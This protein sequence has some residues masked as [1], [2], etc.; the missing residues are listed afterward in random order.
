VSETLAGQRVLIVEDRYLIASEMADHVARLGGEVLGP[1]RDVASAAAIV[2]KEPVDM[3]LLDVRLHDEVVFP[4]AATLA[5][6]GVP[7]IFLTGY[8]AQIL[9]PPWRG[10]PTL[11]KPI[12]PARL[13]EEL[14]K[15][16]RPTG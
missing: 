5:E 10:R 8:D 6:R 7:F 11:A 12:N 13:R 9:P 3:A 4:L 16:R 2:L 14:V 1:S 15:L